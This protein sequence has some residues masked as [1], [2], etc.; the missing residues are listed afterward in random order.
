MFGS[1]PST[2]VVLPKG[3]KITGCNQQ[4]ATM[5]DNIP[6]AN[7]MPFGTCSAPTNPAVV[8]AM[9]TPQPCVPVT[10]APWMAASTKVMANKIP[11]ITKTSKLQCA[12]AGTISITSTGQ[13]KVESK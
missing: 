7:I 13:Q 8:A 9:G 6:M 4:M 12:Y 2:L 3:K 10:P 11:V 1:A 5:M